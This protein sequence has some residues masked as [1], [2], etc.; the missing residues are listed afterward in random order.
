M[1]WFL[2]MRKNVEGKAKKRK[3]GVQ[4]RESRGLGD[5]PAKEEA[6]EGS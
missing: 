2:G 6:R 5:P 3:G 1:D 4:R